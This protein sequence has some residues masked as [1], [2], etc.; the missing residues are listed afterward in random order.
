MANHPEVQK[1]L[2][3]VFERLANMSDE[4]F[5]ESVDR[6]LAKYDKPVDGIEESVDEN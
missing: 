5:K 4:E 3:E 1:V 2:D 6:F